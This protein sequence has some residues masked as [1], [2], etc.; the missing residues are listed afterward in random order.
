MQ[1]NPTPYGTLALVQK[2]L[3]VRGMH[4]LC[5]WANNSEKG[6]ERVLEILVDF[7][8]SA[9]FLVTGQNVDAN[10]EL[11]TRVVQEGHAVGN[12][13]YSH[14]DLTALNQQAAS[15]SLGWH[16][17]QSGTPRASGPR[18]CTRRTGPRTQAWTS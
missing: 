11:A 6:Y 12:H 8:V 14:P 18:S 3:S 13:S 5:R 10:L 17:A 7:E 9:T 2:V 16:S 1:L 4:Q 15:T